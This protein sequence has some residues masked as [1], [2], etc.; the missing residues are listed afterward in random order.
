MN[1]VLQLIFKN[2][3]SGFDEIMVPSRV[4]AVLGLYSISEF[5]NKDIPMT[6]NENAYEINFRNIVI[7]PKYTCKRPDNDIGNVL[8]KNKT[9]LAV[10]VSRRV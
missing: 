3:C 1:I 2:Y 6:N 7:H 5:K 9:F 10:A 8:I 4:R